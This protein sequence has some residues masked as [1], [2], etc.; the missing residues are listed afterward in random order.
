MIARD[1]QLV[2]AEYSTSADFPSRLKQD[3][4]D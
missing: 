3:L 4:K 2:I 1:A